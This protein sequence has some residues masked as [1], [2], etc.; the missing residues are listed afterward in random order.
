[1]VFKKIFYN[2]LNGEFNKPQSFDE[3]DIDAFKEFIDFKN[4]NFNEVK[5]KI[6]FKKETKLSMFFK[7]INW[8][9]YQHS[10]YLTFTVLKV[11]D[12]DTGETCYFQFIKH[13][14]KIYPKN[15]IKERMEF[16]NVYSLATDMDSDKNNLFEIYKLELGTCK[17]LGVEHCKHFQ[18]K[19]EFLKLGEDIKK[20][21]NDVKTEDLIILKTSFN[22][23]NLTTESYIENNFRD[24]RFF[25]VLN[26][27]NPAGSY[28]INNFPM[29]Y[30][31]NNK[32][33]FYLETN[34]VKK[35][36][37]TPLIMKRDIKRNW[38]SFDIESEYVT[39]RPI[40]SEENIITHLGFEY[41]SDT[42]YDDFENHDDSVNFCFINTDFHIRTELLK[43]KIFRQDCDK[44]EIYNKL[45]EGDYFNL[46][47]QIK[48]EITN[49]KKN[50]NTY[51]YTGREDNIL[52]LIKKNKIKF[53]FCTEL[54]IITL[55]KQFLFELKNIDSLLTFNGN[56]YDF[57]QLAKRFSFLNK[58]TISR[59]LEIPSLFGTS[60]TKFY[61]SSN[62]NTGFNIINMEMN[63][64][65]Y[66]IDIFN[67]VSKF[68][69]NMDSNSLKE[70]AKSVYNIKALVKYTGSE[71]FRLFIPKD[72][73]SLKQD[74]KRED[75]IE[76]QY[77]K[78]L[79]KFIQ[80]LLS[81][82]YIY[83]NNVSYKIINKTDFIKEEEEI[84][85]IDINK[86]I[87]E[88]QVHEESGFDVLKGVI[89]V[90]I[91]EGRNCD[92]NKDLDDET[93]HPFYDYLQN[94][95]LAKDDI[96]IADK[97]IFEKQSTF[98]IAKYCIH[99]SLLC[100]YLMKDFLIKENI[101][102]LAEIYYLP[103]SQ[104]LLFRNSTNFMGYLFKTCFEEKI[105][106]TKNKKICTKN[107]T[108]GK[109]FEPQEHFL[110]EP[111]Q[112]FDF[113]SLYP[114]IMISYN[115]S[116]DALVLV[117]DLKC[118]LEFIILKNSIEVMFG[119]DQYSIVY[120]VNEPTYTIL[121]FTKIYS[122]GSPRMGLL[123]FM[124]LELKARR[125]YYK[126]K[127]VEYEKD[128]NTVLSINSDML[129][130]CIKVL[131]NSVYGLLGSD[132]HNISCKF[133]SQAV[134]SI[135][136]R[137]ITFLADYFDNAKIENKK[138]KIKSNITYNPITCSEIEKQK[139]FDFDL[140]FSEPITLKLIYGDT[141][142]IMLIPKGINKTKEVYN[143][144]EN[145]YNKRAYYYTSIIGNI[146]V[147]L[148]NKDLLKGVLNL[149]YEAIYF[150][151]IILAKKKYKSLKIEPIE[152][153]GLSVKEI[154]ELNF[155]P[156]ED[157]KGISLKR[158][159]NCI[160]H[161]KCITNLYDIL[162]NEITK[163]RF[164]DENINN[165]V[166]DNMII[167]FVRVTRQSLIEDFVNKKLRLDDFTISCSF[168]DIYKNEN[169]LTKVMVENY[170]KTA[171]ERINKGDRFKYI[172]KKNINSGK[173]L[174]KILNERSP[175]IIGIAEAIEWGSIKKDISTFSIIFDDTV[176][177]VF[178]NG[179]RLFLEI[180]MRKLKKDIITI[181]KDN[182]TLEKKLENE[183]SKFLSQIHNVKKY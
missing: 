142:S 155:N 48:S 35:L 151:M 137:S 3:K 107:Y 112:L 126:K 17:L 166:I 109:V 102:V 110:K 84:Y 25:T 149:E 117:L 56:S 53:L 145:I 116:P 80:V 61:E 164:S 28:A 98:D 7:C 33:V 128:G 54:E 73:Y 97:K 62:M 4:N 41:F 5:K 8:S 156:K 26:K 177:F 127:M 140:E 130:N 94:I 88:W 178:E 70:V 30:S 37:E 122:D 157:N 124:L 170:N 40:N 154:D 106:L 20:N 147:K 141:D 10:K 81:S 22:Q 101:D 148:I 113:E 6:S 152:K 75:K 89:D 57:Q 87:E 91:L 95:A 165:D 11:R 78:Q 123:S 2:V 171:R 163:L 42:Y 1:M 153:T 103:Q 99:D 96:E 138:L 135:A 176:N 125:K 24:F 74:A 136:V 69:P 32:N 43:K 44:D 175:N 82:N 50:K 27:I 150:G 72:Y 158:R 131:M 160:Y 118:E 63:N 167:N 77:K 169:H 115:I 162:Q 34:Q 19:N 13:N 67:Y 144:D 66:G 143:E 9:E 104:A 64:T 21:I 31:N 146:L 59:E 23:R 49:I 16:K 65:Y 29:R 129:Q 90:E 92:L 86:K 132:F 174:D 133:T 182:T 168:K 139:E 51:V 39:K 105:F 134:T 38:V 161:K 111:L 47:D 71:S 60:I 100:R 159:D 79:F 108:G 180:Y 36:F 183:E 120:N 181:F 18:D 119:P 14:Y 121:V 93:F 52:E 172:F 179:E 45:R 173:N 55:F 83:I 46:S 68:K 15:L 85:N 58:K 76:K 114:S 12:Y